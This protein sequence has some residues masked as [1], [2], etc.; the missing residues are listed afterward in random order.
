MAT[1]PQTPAFTPVNTPSRIESDIADLAHEG[2]IPNELNGVFY[3]VQPDPQCAERG[4][5]GR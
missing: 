1:F 5:T 2:E 3:R 4:L